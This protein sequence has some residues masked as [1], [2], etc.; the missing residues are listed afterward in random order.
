MSNI[1]STPKHKRGDP[2]C[3]K[4]HAG[5]PPLY[6]FVLF[7]GKDA[8]CHW[9]RCLGL[10][11]TVFPHQISSRDLRSGEEPFGEFE[12]LIGED[13]VVM[14]HPESPPLF[15]SVESTGNDANGIWYKCLGLTRPVRKH[16]IFPRDLP[17]GEEPIHPWEYPLE[18]FHSFQTTLKTHPGTA[19]L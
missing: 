19:L 4:W 10:T 14:W 3:V 5:S 7:A 2:V 17:R 9:Y 1:N 15:V 12:P 13:V 6:V 18:I 16:Q 8:L 11:R